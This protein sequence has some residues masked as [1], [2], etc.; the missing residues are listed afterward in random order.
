[1]PYATQADLVQRFGAAEL[2]Q[3]S[4]RERPAQGAIVAA[5]VQRALDDAAG[6]IDARLGARF[7][8]P[9]AP[10]PAEL[11]RVCCDI[12][13]YL[14]H[15]LAPPE[16]VRD[17]HADALKWLDKVASGALPLVG[18][19]GLPVPTSA[20]SVGGVAVAPY[21]SNAAFGSAFAQAWAPAV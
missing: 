4:D 10:A 14:L 5:V 19:D 13:R 11:V 20:S 17:H 3:L 21:G 15:D 9:V 12:A 1:M 6:L 7:A 18:A 2:E 8:V 16:P